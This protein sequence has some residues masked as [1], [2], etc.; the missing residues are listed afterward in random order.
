[1]RRTDIP[2]VLRIAQ[3]GVSL[4][5]VRKKAEMGRRSLWSGGSPW[6]EKGVTYINIAF[7]YNMKNGR[8]VRR[9]YKVNKAV[10]EEDIRTIFRGQIGRAHV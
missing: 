10:V 6:Q 2:A 3:N 7:Q 5:E 9:Y 4:T 8:T 1:M